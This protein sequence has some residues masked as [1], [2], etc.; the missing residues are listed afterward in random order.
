MG[1]WRSVGDTIAQRFPSARKRP[2]AGFTSVLAPGRLRGRGPLRRARSSLGGS[3]M[4]L[5]RRAPR[6]VYCVYGE[7]E[8]LADEVRAQ[9]AQ[10]LGNE[11][12]VGAHE[13][14]PQR[15]PSLSAAGAERESRPRPRPERSIGSRTPRLVGVG[16]LLGVTVGAIALVLSH[17]THETPP[18]RGDAAG[19]AATRHMPP[20]SSGPLP[21]PAT[22]GSARSHPAAS[23]SS[24]APALTPASE[25]PRAAGATARLATGGRHARPAEAGPT[26]IARM[27][28]TQSG[29]TTPPGEMEVPEAAA[30]GGEEFDFEGPGR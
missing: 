17:M 28:D 7:D 21:R 25:D 15:G 4:S 22:A 23:G 5:W 3:S 20:A 16:L 19:L 8:Y 6:Q 18:A 14:R 24:G 2:G 29:E 10:P 26:P 13:T 1:R 30:S 9:E 11:E 12:E 27:S